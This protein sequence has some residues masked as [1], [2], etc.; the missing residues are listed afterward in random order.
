MLRRGVKKNRRN[1]SENK[2]NIWIG[3]AVDKLGKD[4]TLSQGTLCTPYMVHEMHPTFRYP[5]LMEY[6]DAKAKSVGWC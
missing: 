2:V 3:M 6:L 1:T 5:D 4:Q